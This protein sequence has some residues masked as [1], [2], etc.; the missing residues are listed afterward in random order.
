MKG[1]FFTFEGGEGSGK[2][3]VI[4]EVSSRLEELGYKVALTREP[5]GVRIS[6]QIREIILDKEN[7]M[8]ARTEALLY[9]ASRVEHLAK[10]VVPFLEEGY[11]VISDRYLDSSLAYQ[12]FGRGLGLDAV[13]KINMF[14]LEYE[15]Q[16]TFFFDVTPNVGLKRIAGREKID[17]LDL[18]S[19]DFHERVYAGYLELLE[20]YP[21]RMIRINGNDTVQNIVETVFNDILKVVKDE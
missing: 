19:K 17:R 4:K 11:I 20:R 15:P 1:Y 13:L 18:E 10:K 16:K 7:M 2:S 6:E 5:G 21:D 12:G 8:D 3:T 9:A 14:A